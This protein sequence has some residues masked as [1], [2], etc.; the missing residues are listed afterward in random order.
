MQYFPVVLFKSIV[1][2]QI[3]SSASSIHWGHTRCTAV[4]PGCLPV[5]P[6][7]AI[8]EE[9]TIS[10]GSIRRGGGGGGASGTRKFVYHQCANKIFPIVNFFFSLSGHFG[11]KGGKGGSRG[12]G[13]APTVYG[14]SNTSLP[15]AISHLSFM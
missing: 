15:S 3:L 11:L 9:M 8:R 12:G 1:Y 5:P 2:A 13:G 6:V 14:H 10:Q 4:S 7:V